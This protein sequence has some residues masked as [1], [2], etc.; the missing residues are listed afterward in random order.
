[1]EQRQVT[2][3][4]SGQSEMKTDRSRNREATVA[5]GREARGGGEEQTDSVRYGRRTDSN[6]VMD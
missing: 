5:T 4:Y 2:L 1:M 3:S 6:L